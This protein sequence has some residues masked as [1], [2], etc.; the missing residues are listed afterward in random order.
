MWLCTPP[1]YD[2]VHMRSIAVDIRLHKNSGY[3]CCSH[4]HTDDRLRLSL[5]SNCTVS[6]TCFSPCKHHESYSPG[7]GETKTQ[8]FLMYWLGGCGCGTTSRAQGFFLFVVVF[9]NFSVQTCIAKVW[10]R[11]ELNSANWNPLLPSFSISH[12]LFTKQEAKQSCYQQENKL[13]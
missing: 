3:L 12:M 13:C 11:E 10:K 5:Y 8:F 7:S 6:T 9:F 4:S 1:A 2:T